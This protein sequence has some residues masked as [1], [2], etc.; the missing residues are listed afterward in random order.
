MRESDALLLHEHADI[1]V[2]NLWSLAAAAGII[3]GDFSTAGTAFDP[4]DGWE[5]EPFLGE[6][7]E[8]GGGL[9]LQ[10]GSAVDFFAQG[11]DDGLV[12]TIDVDHVGLTVIP[13][14]AS[15]TLWAILITAAVPLMIKSSR[16]EAPLRA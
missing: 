2:L 5:T 3:N 11:S 1:T 7:P 4:F 10:P 16:R 13:E 14:P 9:P 12:T 6:P 8:D 15:I